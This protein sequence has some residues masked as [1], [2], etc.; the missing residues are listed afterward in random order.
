MCQKLYKKGFSF[1]WPCLKKKDI[2][3]L[4]GKCRLKNHS[5]LRSEKLTGLV[6]GMWKEILEVMSQSDFDRTGQ[7]GN[8]FSSLLFP[9]DMFAD[10]GSPLHVLRFP[11]PLKY[12][13]WSLVGWK[14][15]SGAVQRDSVL[16][17]S[18]SE[19]G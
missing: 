17:S 19:E 18:H 15:G 7:I 4:T 16:S 14:W 11:G 8:Q 1:T 6:E 12:V 5:S 13:V 2:Y 10:Y 3:H 9:L